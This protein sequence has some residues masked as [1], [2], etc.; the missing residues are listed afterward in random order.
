[1]RAAAGASREQRAAAGL[2]MMMVLAGLAITGML[3][4]PSLASKTSQR[5]NTAE[6]SALAR[7]E[8]G[9]RDYVRLYQIIPGAATWSTSLGMVSGLN[10]T[11]INCVF[12]DFPTDTSVQRVFVIDDFL[13]GGSPILPYTQ[14]TNGLTGT[15]TN[16]LNSRARA[17]IVSSTKRGLAVPISSG[18]LTQADFDAI[19]NWTYN[20]ATKAPPTGWSSAWTG[21]GEFL[22]VKPLY[23]PSLFSKITLQN[24][25]YGLGL[26]NL[27]TTA[28]SGQT[29]YYFLNGAPMTLS[30]A[31]GTLKHRHVVR[32]D[33]TFDLT[34]SDQGPVLWFK[35]SELTGAIA[36]NNGTYGTYWK[37]VFTNG[38]LLAQA[39]PQFP[40]FPNFASDNTAAYFDGVTSYV[41]TGRLLTNALPAFTL[42][43]WVRPNQFPTNSS[44]FLGIR[45]ALALET[46]SLAGLNY[47]QVATR[48]GGTATAL[49]P[50]SSNE[51]HHVAAVGNG[52]GVTLYLDGVLAGTTLATCTNYFYDSGGTFRVGANATTA[53]TT[54]TTNT[55]VTFWLIFTITKR[56]VT[57]TVVSTSG[58]SS[59]SSTSSSSLA[60]GWVGTIGTTTTS[61]SS[62]VVTWDSP[63]YRGDVDN[64]VLYHRALSITEIL[65]LAAGLSP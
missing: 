58:T 26:V 35:F 45:G 56:T 3:L 13:G 54:I 50:Y 55:T 31:L 16:L 29:D 63:V 8:E 38:V 4:L 17:M 40:T 1:M 47:V 30:T 20:P 65:S 34:E 5:N 22:H 33:A 39:G 49:Y 64:A 42:A 51:W 14:A 19:W 15:Q 27:V 32:G 57:T 44:T 43:G 18:Y 61:A 24:G 23:L 46:K 41:E 60:W 52:L 53:T 59:S 48:N 28:V 21:N 7:L 6:E 25:K 12:P 37:G 62:S 9:F 11:Q 10:A 36:T 2:A